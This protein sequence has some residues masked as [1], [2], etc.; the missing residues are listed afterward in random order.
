[1][2]LLMVVLLMTIEGFTQV[3]QWEKF[4]SSLLIEVT[5]P[6]GVFTCTGVAI[7]SELVLTAAHCL[8]G[9]VKKVR[10]FTQAHYDPKQTSLAITSFKLHPEYN[11]KKSRYRSD[12]AKIKM[13][14]KLPVFIRIWP[15]FKGEEI[16]GDLYRFGFGERNKKNLRTVVT[17]KFRRMNTL[18]E[19][20]ELDDQFSR[21]GDSGGPI[22]MQ[23]GQEVK[24]LAIHSTFSHG[25]QG[26][27]SLN[28]MLKSYL[29]WIFEN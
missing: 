29:P 5:R 7:S 15:I 10:V 2:K 12:L 17:P 4:N 16:D 22:F 18:E 25:P 23:K 14:D 6:H 27:Y 20:V 19:V 3:E 9:E 8:E 26:Q 1:M 13:K 28:P 21:S 11:A 24:V